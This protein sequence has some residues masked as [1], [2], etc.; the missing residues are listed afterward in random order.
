MKICVATGLVR[1]IHAPLLAELL[2]RLKIMIVPLL[3]LGKGFIE[4]DLVSE[5]QRILFSFVMALVSSEILPFW[6]RP[7]TLSV[8]IVIRFLCLERFELL[9]KECVLFSRGVGL[10]GD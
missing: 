10:L 6:D 5:Q 8:E 2:G 1:I 7:L 9:G 4:D 3:V